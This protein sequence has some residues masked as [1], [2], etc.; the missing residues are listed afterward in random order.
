M[1][2][3]NCCFLS[4]P[5][6]EMPTSAFRVLKAGVTTVGLQEAACMVRFGCSDT[7]T[8]DHDKC[9]ECYAGALELLPPQQRSVFLMAEDLQRMWTQDGTRMNHSSAPLKICKSDFW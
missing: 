1:Y 7:S 2:I 3:V 6:V 9:T 4:H 8:R 5:T